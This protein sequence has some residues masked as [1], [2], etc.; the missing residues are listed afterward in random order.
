[1]QGPA[2]VRQRTPPGSSLIHRQ[3]GPELV[4]SRSGAH[5]TRCYYSCEQGL[6]LLF[7]PDLSTDRERLVSTRRGPA[8]VSLSNII[9]FTVPASPQLSALY[10]PCHTGLTRRPL[11]TAGHMCHAHP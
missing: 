4:Y 9:Q 7:C 2:A 1:M 5:A 8:G 11:V 10:S 6:P 3:A